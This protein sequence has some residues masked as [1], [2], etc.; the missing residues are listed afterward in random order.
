MTTDLNFV[1]IITNLIKLGFKEL[2]LSNLKLRIFLFIN[3]LA[4]VYTRKDGFFMDERIKELT[5]RIRELREV[6]GYTREELAHELEIPLEV[7][8]E[9]ETVGLNIPINVIFQ[10]ANKFGVDFNELLSGEEGKIVTYQVVKKGEGLN[11]DRYPGYHFKDLA[12]RYSHK[13]MQPLL[14]TLDPSKE[15][16]D[17]VSHSGQEFNLVLHG[18]LKLTFD[19]KEIIL[20]EGDCVYFNPRHKH[21]QSCVGNA[22]ATFLTV[23]AE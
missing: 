18:S 4:W 2:F 9:Y 13:V 3:V 15:P 5:D 6:C 22:P 17:L 1:N 20:N 16:A 12:Y 10:I 8:T 23:I 19:Q 21:G 7:Y 11:A 14:V